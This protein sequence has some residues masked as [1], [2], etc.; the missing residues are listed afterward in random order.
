[1]GCY[2]INAA[3]NGIWNKQF[4]LTNLHSNDK[5]GFF[6][7]SAKQYESNKF[8]EYNPLKM[9]L[10]QRRYVKYRIIKMIIIRVHLV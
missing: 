5:G 2:W 8:L 3:L 1:M 9:V 7:T 10:S 4:S 6:L